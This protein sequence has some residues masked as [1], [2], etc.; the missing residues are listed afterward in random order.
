MLDFNEAPARVWGVAGAATG[1]AADKVAT[2]YPALKA[3]QILLAA[4]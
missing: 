4:S 3:W 2:V 1:A